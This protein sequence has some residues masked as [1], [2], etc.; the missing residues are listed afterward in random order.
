M[1]GIL[2]KVTFYTLGVT[3][4]KRTPK[5]AID[6]TDDNLHL[7]VCQIIHQKVMS[8]NLYKGVKLCFVWTSTQSMQWIDREMG[9]NYHQVLAYGYLKATSV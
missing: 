9:V 3:F 2:L 1:H 7:N 8:I 6:Y 4:K 5:L